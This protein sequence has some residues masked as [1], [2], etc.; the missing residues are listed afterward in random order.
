LVI[1]VAAAGMTSTARFSNTC[2]HRL[3]HLLVSIRHC[4]HRPWQRLP[5]VWLPPASVV[6]NADE[7]TAINFAR[8]NQL[9]RGHKLLTSKG[10]QNIVSHVL[11]DASPA[12]ATWPP[13]GHT[14][15]NSPFNDQ[16]PRIQI[17]LVYLWQGTATLLP[18]IFFTTLKARRP[19]DEFEVHALGVADAETV[20]RGL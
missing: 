16:L 13:D 8:G 20:R 12:S 17:D 10:L 19:R 14:T 1:D 2:L 6:C 18:P 15:S 5:L 3:H 9:L 7:H 4:P 11:D